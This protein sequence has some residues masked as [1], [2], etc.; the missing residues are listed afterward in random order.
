[1]KKFLTSILSFCLI[2]AITIGSAIVLAEEYTNKLFPESFAYWE[3]M[4]DTD[5]AEIAVYATGEI[6]YPSQEEYEEKAIAVMGEENYRLA[7]TGSPQYTAQVNRL[8]ALEKQL[9]KEAEESFFEEFFAEVGL[10]K[11]EDMMIVGV[12]VT[13]ITTKAEIL[14]LVQHERVGKLFVFEKISDVPAERPITITHTDIGNEVTQ[15]FTGRSYIY[16]YTAVSALHILRACVGKEEGHI[17]RLYD[18]DANGEI[19]AVDA[20]WALQTSVKKRKVEYLM[21]HVF[22]D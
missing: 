19:D 1:M 12:S 4:G 15:Y 6:V 20:L 2:A 10:E 5:T 11:T 22:P 8:L 7:L 21:D 16:R 9:I 17:N 13:F 3:S 18:V 14:R